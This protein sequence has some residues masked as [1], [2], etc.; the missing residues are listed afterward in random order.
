MSDETPAS[1][2]SPACGV[3]PETRTGRRVGDGMAATLVVLAALLGMV[4]ALGLR[5][6]AAAGR[7][8][9]QDVIDELRQRRDRTGELLA[10]V[11][12]TVARRPQ[13]DAPE[14]LRRL[15]TEP[16]LGRGYGVLPELVDDPPHRSIAPRADL[17]SL[18]AVSEEAGQALRLARDLAKRA[19][20]SGNV[21]ASDLVAEFEDLRSRLRRLDGQIAYHGHYQSAVI[22]RADHFADRNRLLGL[23]EAAKTDRQ[24]LDRVIAER[25]HEIVRFY[26]RPS[27]AAHWTADGRIVL[28]VTVA[29]D[30]ADDGFLKG[31]REAVEAAFVHAPAARRRGFAVALTLRRLAAAELYPEGPPGPGE[32]LDLGAHVARFP[33]DTFALTTGASATNVLHGRYIVLGP[34]PISRRTLAH[35]FAHL[36]GLDDAYL[37][38]Y[39]GRIDDPYGVVLVE[40]SGL[41]DDLMGNPGHGTVTLEMI[42]RLIEAYARR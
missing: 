36:L 42:D 15:R 38:G 34:A 26:R 40:W 31:F 27:L 13:A 24:A 32:P 28:P 2:P 22:S 35:E 20:D 39:E 19:G 4:S 30:I 21:T 8:P 14:L 17:F 37:R 23:L 29:T 33:K 6:V 18:Q 41:T 10:R 5:D 12:E 3:V 9:W 16:P 25:R 11:R 1:P 7:Y